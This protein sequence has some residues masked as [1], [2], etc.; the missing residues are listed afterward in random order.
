MV[1]L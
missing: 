1:E